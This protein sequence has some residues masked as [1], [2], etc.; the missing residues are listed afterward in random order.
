MVQLFN[1]LKNKSDNPNAQF[2]M[3]DI[4]IIGQ[5]PIG[6]PVNTGE[7]GS[8]TPGESTGIPTDETT[9]GG[10]PANG[11][12][13]N[14]QNN[15]L[16]PKTMTSTSE[17][18]HAKNVANFSSLIAAAVAMASDYNPSRL[19]I[20]LA[21]LRVSETQAQN[22]L[23][24]V[25][26]QLTLSV[27]ASGARVA[28]FKPLDKLV[29]RVFNSFKSSD[30]SEEEVASALTIVRKLRGSR[31]SA[32]L[33][34]EEKQAIEAETG[35]APV[36]RSSSQQSY[37]NR[38]DFFARFILLMKSTPVYSPNETDLQIT[39]LESFYTDLDTKNKAAVNAEYALTNARNVR[40]QV[41]YAPKTGIVDLAG[42]VKNYIKS[43]KGSTSAEYKAVL[44]LKFVTHLP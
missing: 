28:A 25:N 4:D 6:E 11:E 10:V 17:T 27:K 36:E 29:T 12:N 44:P 9:G 38:L 30:V 26:E 35:Q 16:I 32:R 18:G 14:N 22:A 24:N 1:L 19:S 8:D 41:F 34:D 33:T 39:S 15:N 13:T 7:T 3:P 5:E 21:G 2:N 42:D 23:R 31:A 20:T 40:N 37:D 43:A